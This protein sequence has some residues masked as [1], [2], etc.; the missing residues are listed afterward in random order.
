MKNFAFLTLVVLYLF[1]CKEKQH[2]YSTEVL[3]I[4]AE[5]YVR[6]GLYIGQYDEVFVDAYYGPIH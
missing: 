1:S 2:A 3:D 5:K 4:V 6:L